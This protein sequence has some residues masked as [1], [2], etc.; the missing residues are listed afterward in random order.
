VW[1]LAS[2]VAA[3]AGLDPRLAWLGTPQ[4]HF[5]ALTWLLCGALWV[6]AHRLGDAGDARLVAGVAATVGGL[7]GVWSAAELAG[8]KPVHLASSD[9]LVGPLG[10]AAYLGAAEA[11]L[12]PVAIGIAVDQS[13]RP[14]TRWLAG[15]GAAL[16]TVALV[17]SGARAAWA[18]GLLALVVVV[19]ARR[20]WL[21]AWERRTGI[22]RCAGAALVVVAGVVGLA[23]AT[24]TASRVPQALDSHDAGGISRLAEWRVAS[25]VLLAHPLTG[26]GPEGYR[27]AFGSSVDAGY[28][29]TY[30]R[31]PLPDRAHDSLLDVAVTTGF[32]GVALYMALVLLAGAFVWRALRR[33]PPWLA[34]VAAGLIAYTA[35]ALLLFPIAELEPIGWLLAG[36]VSVQMARPE[37]LIEVRFPT[38]SRP[39]VAVG[40]AGAAGVMAFIGVRAVAADR[41]IRTALD[42]SVRGAGTA[43]VQAAAQAARLAPGDIVVRLTAAE[44]DASGGT[45]SGVSQALAQVG[46]GLRISPRD[47]VLVD[48]R[49]ALLLQRAQQTG[50]P[51]DWLSAQ[52][53]LT[54]L[55]SGDPRNPEL[56]LELGVV[57]TALGR[58]ATA[59]AALT[60]AAALDPTSAAPPTDLA[61]VELREGH[62]A[63]AR[64]AALDA[65]HLDPGDAAAAAL[66]SELQR[67][68]H[69]T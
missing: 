5:G 58:E 43:A 10:S 7:A 45:P 46:A 60:S 20:E 65:L 15:A 32:P 22:W 61:L 62:P 34:G 67:G 33:G 25:G 53:D 50:R 4:R 26:V 48:E 8:W 19:C 39:L 59:V 13:W 28:E 42:A 41:D 69:G 52:A 24:G 2:L 57:D 44:V 37:E 12:V 38:G 9:R 51:S 11:L 49:A 1:A 17:G 27:I 35:G 21:G 16:G 47:P 18:G 30:G 29:R 14:R 56:W 31:S 64:Q 23:F 36:L 40:L 6:A 63:Q 66:L 3:A 54:R 55:L 68:G